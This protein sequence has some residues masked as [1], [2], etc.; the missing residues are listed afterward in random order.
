MPGVCLH[1][2]D[3]APRSGRCIIDP[4]SFLALLSDLE[5]L[6]RSYDTASKELFETTQALDDPPRCA[7]HLDALHDEMLRLGTALQSL[8]VRLV[9]SGEADLG[10]VS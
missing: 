8:T 9:A 5:A 1:P 2:F 6:Q 4:Q 7:P 10:E 3:A